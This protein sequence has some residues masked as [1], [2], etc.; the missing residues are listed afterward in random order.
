M[1]ARCANL[2]G[3]RPVRGLL[4]D[5]RYPVAHISNARI[6]LGYGLVLP[7]DEGIARTVSWHTAL[8]TRA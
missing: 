1:V 2:V 6:Q 4:G 5:F 7:H 8:A 3:H